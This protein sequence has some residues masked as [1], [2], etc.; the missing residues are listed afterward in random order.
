MGMGCTPAVCSLEITSCS[1][2]VL[3]GGD[4][5]S[6]SCSSGLSTSGRREVLVSGTERGVADPSTMGSGSGGF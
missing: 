5:A 6:P 3:G 2:L 1:L 4:S